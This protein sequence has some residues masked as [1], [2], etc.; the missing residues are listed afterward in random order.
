MKR[1]LLLASTILLLISFALGATVS[2]S[3][4]T[5]IT[6]GGKWEN[7]RWSLDMETFTLTISGEG[8]M[9][10]TTQPWDYSWLIETVV[11]SNGVTSICDIAFSGYRNLESITIPDTVTSIGLWAFLGCEKLTSISIP[12]SVKHLGTGICYNCSALTS[13]IYCGTEAEWESVEKSQDNNF[14]SILQFHNYVWDAS[15]P[16]THRLVCSV[17]S[18]QKTNEAHKWNDGIISVMPSC[19]ARGEKL[20]H[21]SDCGASKIEFLEKLTEHNFGDWQEYNTSYDKRVCACG[22]VEY[23]NHSGCSSTLS[24][25]LALLLLCAG[26]AVMMER[27]KK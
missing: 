9:P 22:E 18:H 15:D 13:V 27:K 21:C 20:F 11:I 24:G 25:G 10:S 19:S 6:R 12:N 5:K 14:A 8:P 7:L 1:T 23:R 16:A 26:T 4:T 2:V 3:A 17:C